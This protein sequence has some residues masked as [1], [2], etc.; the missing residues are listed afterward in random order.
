VR[1]T[2]VTAHERGLAL[3]EQGAFIAARAQFTRCAS[4]VCPLMVLEEC[5]KLTQV[6]SA[7]IPTVVLAARDPEGR[8]LSEVQVKVDGKPFVTH[9]DGRAKELDVGEHTFEFAGNGA[10]QRQKAV[11]R[12]GEKQRVIQVT[13]GEPRPPSS[14]AIP[15]A[16]WALGGVGI[17]A[18]GGFGYFALHGKSLEQDL[19]ACTPRCPKEQTEE[20]ERTYLVGDVFLGVG[21]LALGAATVIALTSGGSGAEPKSALVVRAAP[22]AGYGELRLRF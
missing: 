12:E 21:V 1:A 17:A 5:A 19:D 2:C 10:T 9:L 11:L 14:A 20:V 18:L 16:S 7:A 3:Q 13:L 4:A 6:M 15:P 22:A 8:E